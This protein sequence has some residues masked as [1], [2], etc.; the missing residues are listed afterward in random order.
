MSATHVS[1][2]ALTEAAVHKTMGDVILVKWQLSDT[3]QFL[4]HRYKNRPEAETLQ[5]HE[6]REAPYLWL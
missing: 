2:K 3:W 1:L 4:I 5:V 6:V